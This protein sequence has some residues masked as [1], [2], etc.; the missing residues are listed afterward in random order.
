MIINFFVVTDVS[1]AKNKHREDHF[2]YGVFKLRDS[3]DGHHKNYD[4]RIGNK[5]CHG[6]N[7]YDD[8]NGNIPITIRNAKGE[9]IATGNTS[10]GEYHSTSCD[11]PYK[12]RLHETDFYTVEVGRRGK[13]N[14][15]YQDFINMDWILIIS[16]G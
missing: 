12:I 14:Y 2:L 15:S 11:F 13:L 16:L 7:G 6:V 9:I 10:V 1:M 3:R 5:E 4:S 8:I